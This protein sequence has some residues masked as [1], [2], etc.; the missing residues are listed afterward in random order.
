MTRAKSVTLSPGPLVVDALRPLTDA[1]LDT[2]LMIVEPELRVGKYFSSTC[3]TF[4]HVHAYDCHMSWLSVE[5]VSVLFIL[6]TT[7][8]CS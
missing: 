3:C 8:W 1:P 7:A 6:H 2:H 5:K 4:G